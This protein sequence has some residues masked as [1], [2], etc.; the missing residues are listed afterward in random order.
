MYRKS[1]YTCTCIQC[2]CIYVVFFFLATK[3]PPRNAWG[4]RD[5]G[6]T[7]TGLTGGQTGSGKWQQ[8]NL[9]E[10][11]SDETMATSVGTFDS[12]GNFTSSGEQVYMFTHKVHVH[13]HVHFVHV[14]RVGY[15]TIRDL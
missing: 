2:T 14:G 12:S 13:V 7:Q 8:Q 11:A 3:L 4:K 10:W 9:P 15:I 1:L 5:P 6:S